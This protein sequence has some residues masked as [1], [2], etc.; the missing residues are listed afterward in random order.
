MSCLRSL[1][2]WPPARCSQGPLLR[3]PA[4]ALPWSEDA[5]FGC[6]RR[7]S[8]HGNASTGRLSAHACA[9]TAS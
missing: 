4:P 2:Q 5:G 8:P 7:L 9:L 6:D 1:Q 3:H